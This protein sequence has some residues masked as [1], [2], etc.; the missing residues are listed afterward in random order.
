MYFLATAVPK[1]KRH[2]DAITIFLH[3]S[4]AKYKL[5]MVGGILS[6]DKP[7]EVASHLG[8]KFQ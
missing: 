8:I 5:V 6:Q 3:I 4:T 2:V 7:D 1:S